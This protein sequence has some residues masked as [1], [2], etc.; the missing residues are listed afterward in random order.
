MLD[1]LTTATSRRQSRLHTFDGHIVVSAGFV[2]ALALVYWRTI[3]TYRAPYRILADLPIPVWIEQLYAWRWIVR[4]AMLAAGVTL[5]ALE[6]RFQSL[7][8]RLKPVLSQPR[9]ATALVVL[10]AVVGRS[11]LLVPGRIAL[12]DG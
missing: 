8:R 9:L 1:T 6:L 3:S 12:G 5:A 10:V 4:G 2:L 11:Y 7:S